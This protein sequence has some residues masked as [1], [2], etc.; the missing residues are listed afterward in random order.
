MTLSSIRLIRVLR[1]IS[2]VDLDLHPSFLCTSYSTQEIV[3]YC[4][5]FLYVCKLGVV[6]LALPLS[7]YFTVH[8]LSVR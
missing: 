4:S 8:T 7:K 5:D 6:T 2:S 3:L 1:K